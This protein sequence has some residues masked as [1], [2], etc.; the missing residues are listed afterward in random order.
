MLQ[1]K[2]EVK[3][4]SAD[5]GSGHVGGILAKMYR[6]I[7]SD[8]CIDDER[9]HALMARYVRAGELSG[10]SESR[11]SLDREL[12]KVVMTW[13]TFLKGLEPIN[14]KKIMLTTKLWVDDNEDNCVMAAIMIPENTQ[15][16]PGVWLSDLLMQ[17]F[18]E[19]GVNGDAYDAMVDKWI[20]STKSIIHK[21][22]KSSI[23]ASLSKELFSGEITWRSYVKGL[24]LAQV[25]KV[26]LEVKLWHTLKR[27]TKHRIGFVL[28][29]IS[30]EGD[31]GND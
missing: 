30:N 17:T 27:P 2:H 28:G 14:V 23:R 13:K 1:R 8:L 4:L 16:A 3:P 31:D 29:D 26:G 22:E 20:L 12:R 18:M 24:S 19:L 10:N 15:A 5:V 6:M 21:R 25:V 11:K 7:L 9:H